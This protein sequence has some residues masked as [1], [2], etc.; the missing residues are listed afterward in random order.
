MIAKGDSAASSHYWREEDTDVLENIQPSNGPTVRLPDNTAITANRKAVLPLMDNLSEQAKKVNII[1]KLNSSSLVSLGQLCDDDCNILLHKKVMYAIKNN[2]IV[3]TGYRNPNDG[4]WDIPV[5]K[6]K[7][8]PQIIN[9]H[10][11]M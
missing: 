7:F 6:E 3:L 11:H 10:Q 9:H 2:K 5:G 1:P 8:H 4:L